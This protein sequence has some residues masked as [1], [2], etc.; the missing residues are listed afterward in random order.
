MAVDSSAT[1]VWH[2]SLAQGSGVVTPESGAFPELPVTWASRTE[3]SKGKTSP[4]ELIASA[5]SSCF[6]MALSHGLSEAGNPP[7]RLDVTA[8]VSFEP[9]VG[10]KGSAL[11]VKGTVPGLD[12]DGFGAAAAEAGKNCPV[13]QALSGIEITVSATLA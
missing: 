10:I 6:S 8:V 7:E 2:G 4:E 13:S 1:T 5:H 11:T 9:G 12:Q 3:R